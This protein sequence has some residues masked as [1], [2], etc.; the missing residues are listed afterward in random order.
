MT[1]IA[2]IDQIAQTDQT[3]Q[4]AEYAEEDECPLCRK[5]VKCAFDCPRRRED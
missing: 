2:Q 1:E 4:L 5:R 3:G